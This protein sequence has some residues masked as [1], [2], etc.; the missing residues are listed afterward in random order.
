MAEPASKAASI[1]AMPPIPKMA[2]PRPRGTIRRQG[3][4][5]HGEFRGA[6]EAKAKAMA[7][8]KAK[9]VAKAKGKGKRAK[10]MAKAKGNG[11]NTGGKGNRLDTQGNSKGKGTRGKSKGKNEGEGNGSDTQIDMATGEEASQELEEELDEGQ[12]P[13]MSRPMG[14]YWRN[15]DMPFDQRDLRIARS[16]IARPAA[17]SG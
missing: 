10:A 9:A 1:L 4:N 11:K 2:P 5:G 13:I 16:I 6:A 12:L 15:T 7:K 14:V 3:E 8:A 17:A